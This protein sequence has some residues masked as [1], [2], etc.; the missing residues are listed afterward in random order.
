MI[1]TATFI[2]ALLGGVVGW[3]VGCFLFHWFVKNQARR[4][5]QE[6]WPVMGAAIGLIAGAVLLPLDW[7]LYIVA[8][9]VLLL[10]VVRPLTNLLN[11]RRQVRVQSNSARENQVSQR[12]NLESQIRDV[13]AEV[14]HHLAAGL[15]ETGPVVTRSKEKLNLLQ[16]DLQSV[17]AQSGDL[18]DPQPIHQSTM[19]SV[20]RSV[21]AANRALWAR[22]PYRIP[23]IGLL[24]SRLELCWLTWRIARNQRAMRFTRVAN[25][26]NRAIEIQPRSRLFLLDRGSAL[27]TGNRFSEAITD[28]TRV[29]G[30]APQDTHAYQGRSEAY[31]LDGQLDKAVVDATKA[32]E[33]APQSALAFCRRAW[34]HMHLEKP[35]EA[36]VDFDTAIKLDRFCLPAFQGRATLLESLE[37]YD[38]AIADIYH[39]IW[40]DPQDAKLL[41]WRSRL[42]L[43]NNQIDEAIDDAKL[44]IEIDPNCKSG[45][46]LLAQLYEKVERFDVAIPV[47][48][49]LVRLSDDDAERRKHLLQRAR[50]YES[51]SQDEHALS[52]CQD[53]MKLAT[54]DE[55]KEIEKTIVNRIQS[56]IPDVQFV[57]GKDDASTNYKGE[58][59]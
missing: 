33:I 15:P 26:L 41:V 9:G 20:N 49:Q 46:N 51:L 24:Y 8:G 36:R 14:E 1:D 25:Y 39:G 32:I 28:Y 30:F 45:H 50:L 16:K 6:T 2:G 48:T 4:E 37:E 58:A 38:N 57:E 18:H 43:K 31:R 35:D 54:E 55:S 52:D 40:L 22:Y 17:L 5:G 27:I 19:T 7:K 56:R 29:I 44:A 23:V 53:A 34:A 59:T 47:V 42:H 13:D 21:P 12:S 11:Q 10:A 3:Q